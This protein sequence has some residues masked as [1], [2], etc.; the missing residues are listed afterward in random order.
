MLI[1]LFN[2]A[3]TGCTNPEPA[4]EAENGAAGKG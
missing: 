3:F 2:L 4:V 1:G